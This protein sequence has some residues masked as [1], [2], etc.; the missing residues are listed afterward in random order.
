MCCAC[1]GALGQTGNTLTAIAAGIGVFFWIASGGMA[2]VHAGR[3]VGEAGF[4]KL[5]AIKKMRP[6]LAEDEQ[7][8]QLFLDEARIAATVES[9]HVVSTLDLDR[10]DDGSLFLVIRTTLSYPYDQVFRH[11]STM[12]R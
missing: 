10:Q 3:R 1:C 9:P 7:F 11:F 12:V 5:V 6:H 4:E 2:D 8:V